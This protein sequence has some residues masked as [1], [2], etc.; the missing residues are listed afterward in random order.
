MKNTMVEMIRSH[1]E[2]SVNIIGLSLRLECY[3]VILLLSSV[4]SFK[5]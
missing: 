3:F 4:S 1:R 5:N 2:G